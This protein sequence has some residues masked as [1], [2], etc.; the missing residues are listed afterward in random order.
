MIEVENL[1]KR[2]G[3]LTALKGI[4]FKVKRGETFAFLGPNGAGKTTTIH[5][6]TTL[7]KPT[8]GRAVVAGYDVVK[9]EK[10]VRKMIGIVFQDPSLDRDLTAYENMLIHAGVYGIENPRIDEMLKPVELWDVRNKVVKFFSGGMQRRL[11]IAS[12]SA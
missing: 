3:N 6:L 8:S 4:S 10:E 7:L 1:V 5:I 11:E 12:S 9:E 2:F